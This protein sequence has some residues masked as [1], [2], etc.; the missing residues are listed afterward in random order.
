MTRS[1]SLSLISPHQEKTF[2]W[3]H[4]DLSYHRSLFWF[5]TI[6]TTFHEIL[7]CRYATGGNTK[8]WI[9]ISYSSDPSNRFWEVSCVPSEFNAQKIF[10]FFYRS[11]KPRLRP[12][13]IRLTDHTTTLNQQ[14][15]A[16]TSPTSGGRSVGIVRPRTKATEL[17][18]DN[19][20]NNIA[21]GRNSVMGG[22]VAPLDRA[23]VNY[24]RLKVHIHTHVH[25]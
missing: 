24:I 25:V 14:K 15:L 10:C 11:R 1:Q 6:F 12:Y 5:Q 3:G 23:T 8:S 16:L 4:R 21:D 9:S 17:V 18:S 20:D 7:D 19:S 22:I 2:L 13:G